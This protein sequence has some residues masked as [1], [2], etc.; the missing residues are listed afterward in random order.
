M[1]QMIVE[2]GELEYIQSQ[3]DLGNI[4]EAQI[5]LEKLLEEN[6]GK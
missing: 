4:R 5:M 2:R 3:L 6:K 1:T